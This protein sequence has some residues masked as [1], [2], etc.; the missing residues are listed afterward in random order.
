MPPANKKAPS[1]PRSLLTGNTAHVP[2][3]L[4]EDLGST[5][6]RCCQELND[7]QEAGKSQHKIRKAIKKPRSGTEALRKDITD[8]QSQVTH[9]IIPSWITRVPSGHSR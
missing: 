2:S 4:A 7:S 9:V 5:A 6:A 1:K 3:L 8:G